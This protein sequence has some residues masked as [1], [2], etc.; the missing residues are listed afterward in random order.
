MKR[1]LITILT[2]ITLASPLAQAADHS[3]AKSVVSHDSASGIALEGHDLVA[4]F[5]DSK[6]TKGDPQIRATHDGATYLFASKAHKDTF[7]KSPEKYLPEY[8]GYCAVGASLG[9]LLP[10]DISTWKIH[11]GKLYLNFSANIAGMFAKDIEGTLK[12]AD[13][14]WPKLSAEACETCQAVKIKK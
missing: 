1:I 13:A 4:F 5:T 10:V 7:L 11:E 6:A 9:V 3:C 12:K 2:A 8:G 14:N